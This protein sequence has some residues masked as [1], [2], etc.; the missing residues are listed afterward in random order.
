MLIRIFFYDELWGKS[1]GL[2]KSTLVCRV[3]NKVSMTFDPFMCLS[4]PLPSTNMRRM[5]IT[6]FSTNGTKK[7]SA[8]TINVPKFGKLKDIIQALS[9]A[10]SLRDDETLL[11]AQ[12]YSMASIFPF[13]EVLVYILFKFGLLMLRFL[14]GFC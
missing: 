14:A 1:Q 13:S 11:I 10:C 9:I 2:Y 12:V 4:L 7:P 8:F 5:T 3:C 6:V